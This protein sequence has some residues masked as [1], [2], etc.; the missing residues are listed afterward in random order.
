MH[1]PHEMDD[2]FRPFVAKLI[3]DKAE[4]ILAAQQPSPDMVAIVEGFTANRKARRLSLAIYRGFTQGRPPQAGE[5][6][7]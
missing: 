1:E 2:V 4:L 3:A 7:P 5:P 6:A